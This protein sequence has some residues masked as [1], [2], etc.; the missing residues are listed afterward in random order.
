M[1]TKA[2]ST[3]AHPAAGVPPRRVSFAD[4]IGTPLTSRRF[5]FPLILT[6]LLLASLSTAMGA[7]EIRRHMSGS[8]E[9]LGIAVPVM[10]DVEAGS[11]LLLLL[12]LPLL[13]LLLLFL[14]LLVFLLLLLLLLLLLCLLLLLILILLL[15]I[16][17]LLLPA[18]S[19]SSS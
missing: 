13:L 4:P 17:F 3:A 6:T 9:Q 18:S 16:L 12:L 8:G 15:L 5:P 10:H 19:S 7:E 11:L 2:T 14:L 1:R